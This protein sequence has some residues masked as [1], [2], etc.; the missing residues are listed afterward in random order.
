MLHPYLTDFEH[1]FNA[2]CSI[3]H[4]HQKTL[5]YS[6]FHAIRDFS[7]KDNRFGQLAVPDFIDYLSKNSPI[8]NR[9]ISFAF[10]NRLQCSQCKWISENS[11][12]DTSLKL[13]IPQDFKHITLEEL[14]TY[15]SGAILKHSNS[16]LCSNPICNKK[17]EQNLQREYKSDLF[18]IEI[19]RVTE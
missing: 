13:Y 12:H 16:V 11:S 4:T 2:I 18:V 3:W 5:I 14:L 19:I 8:L 7:G 15:N 17:T 9:E 6:F 10:T 1:S